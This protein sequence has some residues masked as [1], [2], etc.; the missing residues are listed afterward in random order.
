MNK[1]DCE[2]IGPEPAG[3]T[4]HVGKLRV[5]ITHKPSGIVTV[6]KVITAIA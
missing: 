6:R 5:T 2:R 1:D 4:M 3:G